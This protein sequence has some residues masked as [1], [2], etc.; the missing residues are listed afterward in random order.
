MPYKVWIA[1]ETLKAA[2][3]NNT[4]AQYVNATADWTF[5]GTH[6][7]NAPVNFNNP[8]VINTNIDSNVNVVGGNITTNQLISAGS[9]I[10]DGIG[11]V[12]SV[13]KNA[14]GNGYTVQSTDNGKF[15]YATG[16][17]NMPSNIF[18]VGDT[19]T[20]FNSTGST[21]NINEASGTV[22]YLS[23]LGLNGSAVI[24]SKGL[25][26]ILCVDTNI[27]VITTTTITT[28]SSGGG[29]G[30]G[31]VT[32]SA[33]LGALGYVPYNSSNPSVFANSTNGF[34]VSQV[35]LLNSLGYTPY[36]STNPNGYVNSSQVNA[37]IAANPQGFITAAQ[38]SSFS[39][40][41][42]FIDSGIWTVPSGITKCKVQ[43]IGPG[44]PSG[45]SYYSATDSSFGSYI[46][47]YAGGRGGVNNYGLN[48]PGGGGGG[49]TG[50]DINIPGTNGATVTPGISFVGGG[51]GVGVVGFNDTVEGGQHGGSSSSMGSGGGGGYAMK[52]LTGLTP[53]QQIA[54]TIGKTFYTGDPSNPVSSGICIIEY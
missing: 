28:V 26:T 1:G 15:L 45:S 40:A 32:Q 29:G 20:I 38:V 11:N 49:A 44:G 37:Q 47:A 50:G 22:L 48:A 5:T 30:G 19:V 46:T 31:A 35:G 42:S 33:I 12:R 6:T 34:G 27:Y 7:H 10:S 25:C 21:I 14:V 41:T 3:L 17:I 24:D 36:N 23:G 16:D 43:L 4:F 8:I 53:G 2:D 54:V 13:I 9:S 51:Y 18:N 39:G 52:Y